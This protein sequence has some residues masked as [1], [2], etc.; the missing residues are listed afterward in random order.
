MKFSFQVGIILFPVGSLGEMGA[1]PYVI[2]PSA[3]HRPFD[4]HQVI[5]LCFSI[6]T[7]S[8]CFSI[9]TISNSID[10]TMIEPSL[11]AEY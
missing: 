4:S 2:R 5:V 1:F 7:I 6:Q 3:E 8:D 11:L 9:Q 10:R